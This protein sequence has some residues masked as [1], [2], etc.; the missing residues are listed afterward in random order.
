MPIVNGNNMIKANL[1]I[2]CALNNIVDKI[3]KSLS[4]QDKMKVLAYPVERVI[5]L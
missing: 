2:R 4:P 3:I 1:I 5:G